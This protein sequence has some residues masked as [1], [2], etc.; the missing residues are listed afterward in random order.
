MN[1]VEEWLGLAL[2]LVLAAVIG[3]GTSRKEAPD[4]SIFWIF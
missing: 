3:L 2:S 1:C 4:S